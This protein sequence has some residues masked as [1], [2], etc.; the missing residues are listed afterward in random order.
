MN[1]KNLLELGGSVD[2]IATAICDFDTPTRHYK[3]DYVVLDIKDVD[4]V[5]TTTEKTTKAKDDKLVLA[6]VALT[7]TGVSFPL[8]PLEKQIYELLGSS[9]KLFTIIKHDYLACELNGIIL[10]LDY[11]ENADDLKI[12]NVER[13]TIENDKESKTT[14]IKSDEFIEGRKYEVQYVSY[15]LRQQINFDSYDTNIPYLSLQIKIKGNV[16]KKSADSYLFIEKAKLHY[17]PVLRFA[18][19]EVT[20]CTLYFDIID[21]EKKPSLV[22]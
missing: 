8:V 17:D 12:E 22:I 7:M 20:Y 2:L 10:P 6:N 19:Q 14:V 9:K 21:S 16:D 3:K 5:L 1:N 15:E 13:F 11:I 18:N 4:L